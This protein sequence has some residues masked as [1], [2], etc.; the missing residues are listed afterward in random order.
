MCTYVNIIIVEYH[1]ISMDI[2]RYHWF[3]LIRLLNIIELTLIEYEY[4]HTKYKE[5]ILYTIWC[6]PSIGNR[7][8]I[9]Q[10]TIQTSRPKP[11]A[12]KVL[13]LCKLKR[14]KMWKTSYQRKWNNSGGKTSKTH[15]NNH[16][17]TYMYMYTYICICQI[18][19]NQ[20]IQSS[21]SH[22]FQKKNQPSLSEIVWVLC[23]CTWPRDFIFSSKMALS[24]AC[25]RTTY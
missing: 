6:H 14:E 3:I 20:L 10:G 9:D 22:Q 7:T 8:G 2:I 13:E 5:C 15:T 11:K 4:D 16:K 1:W 25:S 17:H 24:L 19:I 23:R 21:V 18:N 12:C